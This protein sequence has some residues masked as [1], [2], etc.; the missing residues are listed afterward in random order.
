MK[1]IKI[2]N[3]P[4]NFFNSPP[5]PQ[6]I[7]LLTLLTG[8][9]LTTVYTVRIVGAAVAVVHTGGIGHTAFLVVEVKCGT[10]SKSQL[11]C[12]VQPILYETTPLVIT[13]RAQPSASLQGGGRGREII[14]GVLRDDT[15]NL[16]F[17]ATSAKP[18]GNK[19]RGI[20]L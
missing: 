8:Q 4:I 17:W 11:K 13:S 3:S 12:A 9:V 18:Y 19:A 5:S 16:I 7:S 14:R 6:N 15:N 1:F 10:S 20:I 2:F